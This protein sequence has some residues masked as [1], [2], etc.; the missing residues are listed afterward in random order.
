MDTTASRFTLRKNAKRAAE[1]MIRK[2]TAPA[3]DYANA[4]GLIII[5]TVWA[6]TPDRRRG[7]RLTRFE[8]GADQPALIRG[9]A[10]RIASR[11]VPVACLG[12]GCH[13]RWRSVGGF[14]RNPLPLSMQ[15]AGSNNP[16]LPRRIRECRRGNR[17]GAPDLVIDGSSVRSIAISNI[18]VCV[19]LSPAIMSR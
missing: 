1:A 7:H 4:E 12:R 11:P 13:T 3:I 6:T 8:D 14:C 9:R 19:L 2:G 15:Q 17:C 16:H 10:I 5:Q 18:L